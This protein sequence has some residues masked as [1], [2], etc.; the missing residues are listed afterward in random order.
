MARPQGDEVP[1]RGKVAPGYEEVVDEFEK[2]FLSRG[3][4]GAA[5]VIERDGERVVDLW[6]GYRDPETGAPWED[7]TLVLVFSSTKGM[8]AVCMALLHSRGQLDHDAPVAEYWPEFA[9]AGKQAVTVRQLLAH[10]AGLCALDEVLTPEVIGDHERLAAILAAQAPA[11]E[12]GQQHGYHGVTIGWYAGELLRRCDPAGRTLGRFFAEE[13]AAPLEVEFYIGFPDDGP[14]DRLADL[15][16][17]DMFQG[18]RGLGD[19]PAR[20]ALSMVS[21]FALAYRTFRN[22]R[23]KRPGEFGRPPLR[24]LEIPAANGIGRASA[25]AAIYSDLAC[26]GARLGIGPDTLAALRAP[27]VDPAQGTYDSVL[28]LEARFALGF[29]RPET[30]EAWGTSPETFG[31]F[32]AG[33]SFGFA[34]PVSRVGFGYVMNRMGF[35]IRDDEREAAL[36]HAFYRCMH[37]VD[38]ARAWRRAAGPVPDRAAAGGDLKVRVRRARREDLPAI[39]G[40]YNQ[41]IRDTT[42]TFDTV[43]KREAEMESWFQAHGPGH[44][45]LVALHDTH[46]AGWASLSAWSDRCAYSQTAELSLYVDAA[47]RGRGVGTRLLEVLLEEGQAGGVH[48]VL[49]RIAE[50][51]PASEHL[52][53]RFG[54]RRVGTMREVGQKFGRRLGV[55]LWERLLGEGPP[56]WVSGSQLRAELASLGVAPG[57]TLMLHAAV[58]RLG[59]VVG[60]PQV[61]LQRLLDLLGPE[62]TLMMYASW[63]SSPYSMAAQT[64]EVQALWRQEF[65]AFDPATSPANRKWSILTEYLRTWPGAARSAHPE[66]SMVAVGRRAEWLV[67]PHAL[68]Y[69]YGPGTPLDRLCQADGK[70]LLLGA[71]LDSLTLLHLAEHLAAVPDKRVVRYQVPLRVD[72]ATAW[73]DVE[74]FDT[75]RGIV[76]WQGDEDYFAAIARQALAQGAGVRGLVGAAASHLFDACRLRDLGVAWMEENLVPPGRGGGE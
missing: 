59:Q 9:A 2:N 71:P 76:D 27:P 24:G 57:D 36:R 28:H 46:L 51:N 33:G 50:G 70:V 44:P 10:Q 54:F 60:G 3:E 64:P 26:G 30:P 13:V 74:E 34:D 69:G 5:C 11:W 48:T 12:P 16:D 19:V 75:A 37:R 31:H 1:L 49:S 45:L 35:K 25:V 58:G 63:E 61:V 47:S 14:T 39:V 38:R 52:H 55:T 4:I 40:I 32:G 73:V 21:P 22:P 20:F 72:G 8:A 41:A 65:P 62:G 67:A 43:E 23:V 56:P 68:D 17:F 66:A 53:A 15:I 42:A 6:G 7:D 18:I 29:M